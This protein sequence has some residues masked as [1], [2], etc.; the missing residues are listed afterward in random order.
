MDIQK[1]N[2][3]KIIECLSYCTSLQDIIFT[4]LIKQ[5]E[6]NYI[7][8]AKYFYYIFLQLQKK[9]NIFKLNNVEFNFLKN[10]NISYDV[11]CKIIKNFN[12]SVNINSEDIWT[13]SFL[14]LV[15]TYN[16]SKYKYLFVSIII[17]Y[18]IDSGLYHQ[19]AIIINF[20]DNI[21]LF[22]EPYGDYNKYEANYTSAIIEFLSKYKFPDNF[23]DNDKLRFDTWHHYFGLEIGIQTILLNAHNDLKEEFNKEKENFLK[24]IN[25]DD[26][27]IIINKLNK[28]KDKEY[29]KYDYTIDTLTIIEYFNNSDR[30]SIK[31]E[32]K[33]LELYYKYNSKTCVTITITELDYYFENLANLPYNEQKEKLLSYYNEFKILKN[34]KLINRLDDFITKVFD[35]IKIKNLINYR[36]NKICN[37]I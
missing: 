12:S 17:D 34:I 32:N 19:C 7:V 20:N 15:L 22:Y 30:P 16:N 10:S 6:Q 13:N 27:K 31:D 36:L 26:A 2:I 29:H 14:A 5:Y 18:C 25:S 28:N 37:E 24:E 4:T 9:N 21:F 33:A 3:S 8:S 23:Y 35:K 1:I 11:K